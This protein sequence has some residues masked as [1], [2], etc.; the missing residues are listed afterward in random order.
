MMSPR[1]GLQRYLPQTDSTIGLSMVGLSLPKKSFPR[2]V[3]A[4]ARHL[5]AHFYWSLS[6]FYNDVVLEDRTAVHSSNWS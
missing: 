3:L 5:L 2:Y 1:V 4:I 6:H